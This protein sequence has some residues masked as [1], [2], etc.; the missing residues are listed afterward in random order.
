M[1]GEECFEVV[2]AFGEM[3]VGG[4][5]V[6]VDAG[7]RFGLQVGSVL[8]RFHPQRSGGNLYGALVNI[9]AIKVVVEDRGCNG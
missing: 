5:Q 4:D 9:D 7:Q 6:P 8:F 3:D 2:F 1:L